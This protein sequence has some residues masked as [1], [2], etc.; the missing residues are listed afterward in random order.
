MN[1]ANLHSLVTVHTTTQALA[2]PLS[3]FPVRAP[4]S[5]VIVHLMSPPV[6]TTHVLHSKMKVCRE[7]VKYYWVNKHGAGAC[8]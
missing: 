5:S 7:C 6:S 8:L 4:Y 2:Q 1:T 3:S